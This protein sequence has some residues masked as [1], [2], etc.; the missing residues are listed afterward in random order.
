VAILLSV[1]LSTAY[2]LARAA[3]AALIEQ[4]GAI[5]VPYGATKAALRS[6]A[7]A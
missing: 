6:S 7:T 4:K 2:A 3:A 5:I 1:N